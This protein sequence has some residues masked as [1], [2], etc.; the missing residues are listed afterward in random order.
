MPARN[1]SIAS[2]LEVQQTG[3]AA[4]QRVRILNFVRVNPGMTR[5]EIYSGLNFAIEMSSICGRVNELIA[6]GFLVEDGCK[7][8]PGTGKSANCP[9]LKAEQAA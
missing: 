1:T 5:R 6:N 3:I 9:Y 8:N 2:F 7:H 4:A